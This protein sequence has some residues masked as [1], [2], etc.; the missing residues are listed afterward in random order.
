MN[1]LEVAKA[2]INK[3]L[4]HNSPLTHLQLQKILFII[5]QRFSHVNGHPL[6][7]EGFAEKKDIGP[8]QREVYM[9][10]SFFGSKEIDLPEDTNIK[11]PDEI[12]AFLDEIVKIPAEELPS[13]EEMVKDM[14]SIV[15]TFS[16]RL[17]GLR[18]YKKEIKEIING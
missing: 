5:D 9:H 16:S 6:I 18:K 1:A 15:H 12:N 11:L 7:D 8:L 2:V 10:Y 3:G 4:E 17:Y 14:L 13:Y